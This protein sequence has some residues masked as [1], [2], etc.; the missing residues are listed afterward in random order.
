MTLII[1]EKNNAAK[2][3]ASILSQGKARR[4]VIGQ[5]PIYEFDK[6]GKS[7]TVI[8]LRGHILNLDYPEEYNQWQDIDPRELIWVKP[9]K[10]IQADKIVTV[11]G[12]VT[13]ANLDNE[14][15]IATDYDR[16]GE[17][18]GVEG[19]ELAKHFNPRVKAKRARFSALTS[20]DVLNAFNNLAEIDYNL[21][22]AAESRQIID[23]H[24]GAAL[25]RFISLASGQIGKDFLSVG[26]VQ[27]PTLALIVNREKEITA[28][29]SEPYWELLA[30][31][32]ANGIR[33]DAKHTADK[34][35][36]KPKA[37][38][39]YEKTKSAKRGTIVAVIK[40]EVHE[41]PPPP[42]NTTTYLQA[43]TALGLTAAAAMR[44][45]EDLYT[46]GWISY[47]RT[48]NTVYPPTINLRAI[49]EKFAKAPESQFQAEARKLLEL[50]KLTPT[51]GK[52]MAT[53][54]PPIHPVEVASK[55]KLTGDQWKVYELIV[56]RFFATLAPDA[57]GETIRVDIDINGELFRAQGYRVVIPGWRSYYP[58]LL[59]A[60]RH[61]P[62]LAEKEQVAVIGMELLEKQTQPPKR[63]AQGSLIQLMDKYGLGTKS[64]RHE[65]I[66]KLIERGYIRGT[67]LTP[68]LTAFAVTEAL[69]TYAETITKPDMTA[70]LEQDMDKIAEGRLQLSAV[71]KESQKL[72]HGILEKMASHKTAIGESIR[73]ALEDQNVI[74]TCTNP[75]CNGKLKIIRSPRGK[76]FA[77]CSQFPAC[78][79]SYPLPQK[80]QI[81]PINKN[82]KDC[83]APRVK[84]G[85]RRQKPVEICINLNCPSK[86]E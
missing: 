79:I 1:C 83:G 52:R 86:S 25:T 74:G 24:W 5:V 26:R 9:Y 84:L 54:H 29:K 7:Y 78:K 58:Y 51:R 10:R 20:P 41:K 68:T 77:G 46:N 61:L 32:E 43:S 49:L 12:E 57:V 31:L 60:E 81:I 56:R 13:R 36:E 4:T 59:R 33:F 73:T 65:I 50:P 69:Q 42:F 63:Y 53:D 16:E 3:I 19:L 70:K 71:V 55:S 37:L 82:C 27:S 28:F 18:I 21:S 47:P 80:G 23:L 14:I 38:A 30:H 17:L 64:T 72:L 22:S 35:W 44:I 67:P 6:D 39:V 45:A 11:L 85:R 48:D 76:R 15:I 75:A 34:F 8:G 62:E 40:K 66:Q 2:R